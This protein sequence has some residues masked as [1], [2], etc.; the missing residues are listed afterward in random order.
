[1]P[2]ERITWITKVF[3]FLRD[4][5]LV[6]KSCSADHGQGCNGHFCTRKPDFI[7]LQLP[8]CPPDKP[9]FLTP[10]HTCAFSN[11]HLHNVGKISFLPIR[12]HSCSYR[13][14]KM[15]HL[16]EFEHLH[17]GIGTILSSAPAVSITSVSACC[18]PCTWRDGPLCLL[19][20]RCRLLSDSDQVHDARAWI[21]KETRAEIQLTFL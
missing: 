3:R 1:M 4:A 11:E 17:A 20:R 19:S 8:F 14:Q 12:T 6:D 13:G 16:A 18:H 2:A 5:S 9:E 21:L 15:W 7:S 10:V